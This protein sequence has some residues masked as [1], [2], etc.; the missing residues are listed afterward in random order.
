MADG[1]R[2]PSAGQK[3]ERITE[4]LQQLTER[5]DSQP[6]G[7][8]LDGERQSVHLA[9]DLLNGSQRV[10]IQC[11]TGLHAGRT[12]GEQPHG[13]RA[14]PAVG[15]GRLC[16]AQRGDRPSHLTIQ[17]EGLAAGGEYPQLRA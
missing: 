13:I 1:G 16:D 14:P 7:R 3:R 4:P 9:A 10:L 8:Q 12:L 6:G 5:K 11:E 17:S 15:F 2:A